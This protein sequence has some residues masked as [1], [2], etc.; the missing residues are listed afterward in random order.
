MEEGLAKDTS[1]KEANEFLQS[2]LGFAL[3][4]QVLDR[5][6]KHD[7]FLKNQ[8]CLHTQILNRLL[9]EWV[10][11]ET[12]EAK[13]RIEKEQKY[14][15]FRASVALAQA[16]K[17]ISK[18]LSSHRRIDRD[19][20]PAA[21]DAPT[22]TCDNN[23]IHARVDPKMTLALAILGETLEQSRPDMLPE[24]LRNDL[25][26]WRDSNSQEDSWGYSKYNRDTM[27]NKGYC[28][29]DIRRMEA[30]MPSVSVLYY[31]SSM[32]RPN[33]SD[34]VSQCTSQVCKGRSKIYEPLHMECSGGCERLSIH[35]S[36]MI[37]IINEGK[38][39]M[40][41][42]LSSGVLECVAYD[43][44]CDAND[45]EPFGVLSHSWEEGIVESGKDVHGE[46]NRRMH[47]CQIEMLRKTFNQLLAKIDG[48]KAV[49]YPFWVD[50]LCFPRQATVQGR[51]IKQLRKIYLKASAVLVWDKSL[52]G[53]E[54]TDNFIEMNMR[55]RT[56]DWSWRLWTFQEAILADRLYIAFKHGAT[57]GIEELQK[58]RDD[59][60]K[61]PTSSYYYIWKAGHPFSLPIWKLR[62]QKATKEASL[63]QE[64]P[65]SNMRYPSINSGTLQEENKY[66]VARAWQAVQYHL[67]TEP[68]DEAIVLASV[69]GLDV[70]AIQLTADKERNNQ[71]AADQRM[72]RLL[73]MIDEEPT[74][75]IPSGIIFLPSPKLPIKGYQWAPRTW[76]SKQSHPYPLFRPL[77]KTARL[78]KRGALVQFPGIILHCPTETPNSTFHVPLHETLHKWWKIQAVTDGEDWTE[79]WRN[80]VCEYNEPC[81]ILSTS[82]PRDKYEIGILVKKK[83][84]LSEGQIRW[85]EVLCRVW[86]RLE[87]DFVMLAKLSK[88]YMENPN[89]LMFGVRLKEDQEWCVDGGEDGT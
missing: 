57:V 35:E 46:N 70:E 43:L 38:T 62:N 16:R 61:D 63:E 42:L 76:L 80:K 75:G 86:V 28:P 26:F 69:L 31:A 50:V 29:L 20:Y 32:H 33:H 54:K 82:N 49:N 41:R 72:A 37:E 78:L 79:F 74:L 10:M 12:I 8:N 7:L 55:I 36:E 22:L 51:A 34:D 44:E 56:G 30:I 66:R 19:D 3:L 67:V 87:T 58:A 53:R 27:Q 81:I 60:K 15:H 65:E 85:V 23:G 14:R 6:I 47:V 77:R 21:Q 13:P 4:A 18:H 59:A 64:G 45:Q 84:M 5:P 88:E 25:K 24:L 1:T 89:R 39:P 11:R 83:G 9:Q 48:S 73:Y 52:L 17:F 40:V 2:W 71:A 68:Q